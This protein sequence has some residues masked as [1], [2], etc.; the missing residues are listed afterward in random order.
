MLTAPNLVFLYGGSD[1]VTDIDD[2]ARTMIAGLLE[3]VNDELKNVD[4]LLPCINVGV[5]YLSLYFYKDP[6]LLLDAAGLAGNNE[7]GYD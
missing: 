7:A 6:S 1:C 5:D 2:V 4:G 3:K